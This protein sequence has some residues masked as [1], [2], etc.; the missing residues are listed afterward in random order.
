MQKVDLGQLRDFLHLADECAK[1]AVQYIEQGYTPEQIT[2]IFARLFGD[3]F[4]IRL[5]DEVLRKMPRG[6]NGQPPLDRETAV[7]EFSLE[8]AS[9]FMDAVNNR[10]KSEGK[11]NSG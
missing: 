3:Q 9:A 4:K 1:K 11:P 7:R 5:T 8:F 2:E 10:F 6:G